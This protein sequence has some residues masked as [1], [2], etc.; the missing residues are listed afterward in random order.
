MPLLK[1]GISGDLFH[2]KTV[3]QCGR[4]PCVIFLHLP[5]KESMPEGNK[6]SNGPPPAHPD[7]AIDSRWLFPLERAP[8]LPPNEG[9]KHN[10][11][12]DPT[13]RAS[14]VS[15]PTPN[16]PFSLNDCTAHAFSAPNGRMP[17][18]PILQDWMPVLKNLLPTGQKWPPILSVQ[19][20]LGLPLLATMRQEG[21][22]QR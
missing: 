20:A 17:W 1:L 13:L 10:G 15:Q 9:C 11:F 12:G 2:P 8:P 4:H 14:N 22:H 21:L 3:L 19:I 18:M 5:M 6:M 16:P 7:D